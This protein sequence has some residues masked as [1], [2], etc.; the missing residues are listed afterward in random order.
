MKDIKIEEI[1]NDNLMSIGSF[2]NKI[3]K[4]YKDNFKEILIIMSIPFFINILIILL[5]EKII[6]S[7][8][9]IFLLLM[10][11]AAIIPFSLLL[12][13]DKNK[14]IGVKE[15][16]KTIIKE[17]GLIIL[18][19]N[20]LVGIIIF[21][22]FSL[23]VVPGMYMLTSLFAGICFIILEDKKLING[24]SRSWEYSKGKVARIFFRLFVMMI[25]MTVIIL[26]FYILQKLFQDGPNIQLII[27]SLISS[28]IIFPVYLISSYLIYKDL[29][30]I[31]GES[32]EVKKYN[33]TILWI[34][35]GIGALVISILIM[36]IRFI[37]ANIDEIMLQY[38]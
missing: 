17:K 18:M 33:K 11:L 25:M 14:T 27:K 13:L 5:P 19:F 38:N 7:L 22:G 1:K 12:Y 29:K 6:S 32:L 24:L 28:F 34:L 3:F 36:L 31:K 21:G 16:I 35:F 9:F 10:L 23:L 2:F 15:S 20:M 30:K 8:L 26:P 4:T 37:L